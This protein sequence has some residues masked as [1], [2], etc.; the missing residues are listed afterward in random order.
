MIVTSSVADHVA[1]PFVKQ[2]PLL[3][4]FI[5][6]L[7]NVLLPQLVQVPMCH[8][9]VCQRPLPPFVQI[10]L[11]GVHKVRRGDCTCVAPVHCPH[12]RQAPPQ[13]SLFSSFVGRLKLAT[14]FP[15]AVTI[16]LREQGELNLPMPPMAQGESGRICVS[17][18]LSGPN[19][20]SRAFAL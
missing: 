6:R 8:L 15:P 18:K 1:S 5:P 9:S 3:V 13:P 4:P 12:R 10:F 19:R 2:L 7:L 16:L 14:T 11:H 17:A 20:A